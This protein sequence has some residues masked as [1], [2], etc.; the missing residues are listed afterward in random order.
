M[1]LIDRVAG[2]FKG[3]AIGDAIGKQT[4]T[5]SREDVQRWYPTGISG[6]HGEPGHTIPRYLGKRYEWR[7]GETTD[8]T[9][10]TLAVVRA[11]LRDGHASHTGIG[12]ELLQ[13][14][15]SAHPGVSLWMFLA[16]GDPARIAS[17]GNG[18]GAAMRSAPIGVIY[19]SSNLDDLIQGAFEC[20]IPTHGGQLAICAAAAVAG[21]VSAALE[22]RSR[23]EALAVAIRASKEAEP[24]RPSAPGVTMAQSIESIHSDLVR[25]KHLDVDELAERYFPNS[26]QLIVPLAISLALVT[27]SVE[28]SVLLAANISGDSDS[29]ASIGGAIAGALNPETIKESWCDV[30]RTVNEEYLVDF[31]APLLMERCDQRTAERQGT[32]PKDP[33][34]FEIDGP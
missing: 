34:R 11:I 16:I 14:R 27:G 24:L 23:D 30:V 12:R 21:A 26:P 3:L 22:G 8:D 32:H 9:E 4:E 2:C 19:S 25:R 29:V 6:F 33:Q 1:T 13:C 17:E 5:L 15:K 10:Q 7:I 31:A 20:A 28:E 18:C